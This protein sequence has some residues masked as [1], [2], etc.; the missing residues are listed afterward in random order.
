MGVQPVVDA[1][2]WAEK[3]LRNAG[4]AGADWEKGVANPSSSPVG[5]MKKAKTRY[6]TEM[7]ASLNEDRW[8]KAVD[9]L[10]DEEISAAALAVGGSAFV[11]GIN[12]RSPKIR[13]AIAKLQ[14]LVLALKQR[15][16][17]MPVDTDQQREAKM[18]EAK[19]GMQALGKTFRGLAR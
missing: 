18:I 4:N 1:A 16:D 2:S 17:A 14:P 13:N 3:M 5:G 9:Q 12:A 15:L 10:T 7:T 19:R 6:K 8:G 11:A